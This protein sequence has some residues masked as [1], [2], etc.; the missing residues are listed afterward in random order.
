[1][2]IGTYLAVPIIN[3]FIQNAKMKEIEYYLVVFI[4]A[5]IFYQIMLTMNKQHAIDLGFFIG[6]V[7]YLIL[8]YYLSRKEFKISANKII[9][10][11]ILFI[12]TTLLKI[13]Y[14]QGDTFYPTN[15]ILKSYLDINVLEIIQACAIFLIAKNLYNSTGFISIGKKVVENNLVNKFIISV[16]RSTYGM[17]LLHTVLVRAYIPKLISGFKLSGTETICAIIVLILLQFII[18]WII[19]LILGQIPY[20]KKVS[21]YA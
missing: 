17:Y 10:S 7:S 1:M 8:G 4:I 2:I 12:I 21:G 19:T 14:V 20:I 18:T 16:S 15:Y 6:P 9:I 5:S 11:L 3:K 13:K